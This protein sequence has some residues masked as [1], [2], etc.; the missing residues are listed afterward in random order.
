VQVSRLVH[1]LLSARRQSSKKNKRVQQLLAGAI[2]EKVTDAR[3][4]G[5]ITRTRH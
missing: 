2:V 4:I 1:A 5:E 3:H